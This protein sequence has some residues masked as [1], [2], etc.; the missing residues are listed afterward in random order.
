MLAETAER[1]YSERARWLRPDFS[2][3][4]DSKSLTSPEKIAA[5]LRNY[6]PNRH[7][8][9]QTLTPPPVARP[10]NPSATSFAIIDKTGSTVVCALT[11]NNNFGT[12]R[13]ARGMGILLAAVPNQQGRGPLSLGPVLSVNLSTKNLHFA[14]AAAGGVAAPT[15]LVNVMA[16]A[17]LA[18]Q[19]LDVS[20]RARRIHHGGA[21]DT[22]YY[23]PGFS[24][25]EIAALTARGHKVA[26]TPV[27][28]LVN[29]ID[30]PDG[31]PR[32]PNQCAIATDPRGFGLAMPVSQ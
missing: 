31:M 22:T 7:T 5:L 15:A 12:G 23:E 11:M 10:Q 3:A 18:E 19:S 8:D 25:E 4:E 6:D 30:C 24:R 20:I 21:P 9:P 28:G 27:L 16:R 2:S 29:A 13:M 17:L 32:N 14:G 26:A 1:A